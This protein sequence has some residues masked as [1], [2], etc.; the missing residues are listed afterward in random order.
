MAT[1]RVKV[2]DVGTDIDLIITDQDG[3]VEDLSLA[4]LLTLVLVKPDDV[5]T[6]MNLAAMLSRLGRDD[7]AIEQLQIV[8]HLR[9][10]DTAAARALDAIAGRRRGSP[11]AL[12]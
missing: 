10:N 6:R 5:Q 7:E 8:L 2:G 9:P 12:P 1:T 11:R 4:T 3:E